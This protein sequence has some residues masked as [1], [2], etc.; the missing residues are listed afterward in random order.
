MHVRIVIAFKS[1]SNSVSACTEQIVCNASMQWL[2]TY[3]GTVCAQLIWHFVH[4]RA[5]V[6]MLLR[7]CGGGVDWGRQRI[8]WTPIDRVVGY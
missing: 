6:C 4:T 1:E 8:K 5:L 2:R 7:Q 3:P